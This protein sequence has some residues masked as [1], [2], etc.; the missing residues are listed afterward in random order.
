ML[1]VK[2][3]EYSPR[4]IPHSDWISLI[5]ASKNQLSTGPRVLKK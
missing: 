4:T 3:I 5:F 1:F 2:Y